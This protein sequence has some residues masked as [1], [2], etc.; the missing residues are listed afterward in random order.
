VVVNHEEINQDK[1]A[2]DRTYAASPRSSQSRI[3][4]DDKI[5]DR[6]GISDPHISSFV[7]VIF[8]IFLIYYSNAII[9]IHLLLSRGRSAPAS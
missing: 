5:A 3:S 2:D 1:S 6:G 7:A 8:L 9:H 4:M